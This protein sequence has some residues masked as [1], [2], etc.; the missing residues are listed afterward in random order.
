MKTRNFNK[1]H[2]ARRAFL[3]EHDT[4]DHTTILNSDSKVLVSCPHAVSQV[5]NGIRKF[6]EI[7]AATIA[8]ELNYRT[9]A[10]FIIKTKIIL[11][12]LILILTLRISKVC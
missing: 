8:L 4:N 9:N 12:M 6:S 2:N 5:R 3:K 10:N 1:L 7:G 11:M